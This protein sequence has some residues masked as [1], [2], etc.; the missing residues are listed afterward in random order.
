[1]SAESENAKEASQGAL[2]KR[3]LQDL[4]ACMWKAVPEKEPAGKPELKRMEES[5][6]RVGIHAAGRPNQQVLCGVVP[7]KCSFKRIYALHPRGVKV[8]L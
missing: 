3:T 8:N 7:R 6:D 5:K 2:G 4:L 1:M